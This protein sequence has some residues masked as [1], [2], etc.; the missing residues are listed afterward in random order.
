[1]TEKNYNLTKFPNPNQFHKYLYYKSVENEKNI[2]TIEEYILL[3][4]PDILIEKAVKI[5]ENKSII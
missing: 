1:M 3:S 5:Y 2:K 4:D